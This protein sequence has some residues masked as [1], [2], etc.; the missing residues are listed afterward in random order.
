MMQQL[1]LSI[2]FCRRLTHM[3]LLLILSFLTTQIADCDDRVCCFLLT[4]DHFSEY[5]DWEKCNVEQMPHDVCCF[6]RM[7]AVAADRMSV[8]S[9]TRLHCTGH[10]ANITEVVVIFSPN[11]LLTQEERSE[12]VVVGF[13]LL[14]QFDGTGS[15][16]VSSVIPFSSRETGSSVQDYI[17]E[18]DSET[19]FDEL[20]AIASTS[21]QLPLRITGGTNVT[22]T[23]NHSV[24][25]DLRQQPVQI[26]VSFIQISGFNLMNFTKLDR[27]SDQPFKLFGDWDLSD[28]NESKQWIWI[29]GVIVIVIGSSV[30]LCVLLNL[31]A[32]DE[33]TKRESA[34]I[35]SYYLH[36]SD[37]EYF[38]E[39]DVDEAVD[40]LRQHTIDVEAEEETVVK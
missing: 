13:R 17:L 20:A 21:F 18:S 22:D 26:R 19:E 31:Y 25:I 35:S 8:V 38:S 9:M 2:T 34:L 36:E 33:V 37:D 29:T 39:S 15:G 7:E 28:D 16:L 3:L 30:L 24:T 11:D 10:T 23:G 14:Y 1:L 6:I 32:K 4:L 27:M 12:T 40:N 5:Y